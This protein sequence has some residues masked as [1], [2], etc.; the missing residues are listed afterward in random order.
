MII[1]PNRQVVFY[2]ELK[3][4]CT[5]TLSLKEINAPIYANVKVEELDE[6]T[7]GKIFLTAQTLMLTKAAIRERIAGAM[8]NYEISDNKLIHNKPIRIHGDTFSAGTLVEACLNSNKTLIAGFSE[9]IKDVI[10]M[11]K[12]ATELESINSVN[13]KFTREVLRLLNTRSDVSIF[14][15]LKFDDN[16]YVYFLNR[17]YMVL[18][19]RGL[20]APT[21]KTEMITPSKTQEF[22]VTVFKLGSVLESYMT[23]SGFRGSKVK[24]LQCGKLETYESTMREK[25]VETSMVFNTSMGPHGWVHWFFNDGYAKRKDRLVVNFIKA[26]P[27]C[28]FSLNDTEWH[29]LKVHFGI[30]VFNGYLFKHFKSQKELKNG[31]KN[32][33]TVDC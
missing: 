19:N 5:G 2:M 31:G 27:H 16:L 15:E 20:I 33:K 28:N 10:I 12:L 23:P 17:E 25:N 7:A 1:I 8:D 9:F 32:P 21:S 26:D 3:E 4:F 24:T 11:S 29:R 30:P 18:T 6:L 14:R 13:C 22:F